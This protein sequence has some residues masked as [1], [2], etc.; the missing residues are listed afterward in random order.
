M[1]VGRLGLGIVTARQ[2]IQRA[3]A[4]LPSVIVQTEASH[5]LLFY[6]AYT[7][8]YTSRTQ[9]IVDYSLVFIMFLHFIYISINI[10]KDDSLH[11]N[12]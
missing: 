12:T 9:P 7:S 1:P 2:Q 3:L 10:L 11:L 8:P 6:Y 5:S 4:S